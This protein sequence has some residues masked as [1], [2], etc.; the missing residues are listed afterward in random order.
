MSDPS[1]QPTERIAKLEELQSFADRRADEL[2]E[3]MAA[4]ERKVREFDARL[5]RLEQSL[6]QLNERV[7]RIPLPPE[8]LPPGDGPP[9]A[10]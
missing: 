2:S 4:L 7:E 1:F 6:G 9:Q 5:R 3:Q 8:E 10:L